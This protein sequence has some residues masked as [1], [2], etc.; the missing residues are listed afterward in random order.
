MGTWSSSFC[1]IQGEARQQAVILQGRQSIAV[2]ASQSLRRPKCR[3]LGVGHQPKNTGKLIWNPKMDWDD[4]TMIILIKIVT[5]P[6]KIN[7]EPPKNG[8][9]SQMSFPFQIGGP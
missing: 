5:T 1:D 6:Q 2:P 3:G 4:T 9:L 7:M 8:V